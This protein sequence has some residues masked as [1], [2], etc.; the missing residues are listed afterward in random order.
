MDEANAKE[1]VLFVQRL[2]WVNRASMGVI[3]ED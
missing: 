2:N 1:D 3:V